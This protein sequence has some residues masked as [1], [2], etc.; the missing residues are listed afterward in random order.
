[1]G[2]STTLYALFRYMNAEPSLIVGAEIGV[3][4]QLVGQRL[5]VRTDMHSEIHSY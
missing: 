4:S 3:T 1:M 5:W 2:V